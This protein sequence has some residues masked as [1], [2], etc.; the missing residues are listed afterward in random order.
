MHR[1]RQRL[2]LLMTVDVQ[3][4]VGREQALRRIPA[5]EIIP[6][7]AHQEGELLIA[8]LIFQFHWC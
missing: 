5:R 4:D 6:R 2:S 1:Q 8:P 3:L 7:M